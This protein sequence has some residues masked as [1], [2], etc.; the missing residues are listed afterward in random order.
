VVDVERA[1]VVAEAGHVEAEARLVGLQAADGAV[2]GR[3]V[4]SHG[5]ERLVGGVGRGLTLDAEHEFGVGEEDRAGG[6]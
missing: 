6:Q 2:D 5:D 1:L 3:L 4:A